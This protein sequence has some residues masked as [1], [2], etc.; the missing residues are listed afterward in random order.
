MKPSAEKIERL[1]REI[2]GFLPPPD[3]DRTVIHQFGDLLVALYIADCHSSQEGWG[4]P[5]EA[6]ERARAA[7]ALEKS[8]KKCYRLFG[9]AAAEKIEKRLRKIVQILAFEMAEEEALPCCHRLDA[10]LTELYKGKA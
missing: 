6:E 1:M 2:V 9:Q 10:R 4:E 3:P 8:R 5:V 7:A